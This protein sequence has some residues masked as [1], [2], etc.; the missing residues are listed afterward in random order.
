MLEAVGG[1]YKIVGGLGHTVQVGSLA[2]KL[3]TRWATVV[4]VELSA[5]PQVSL[6]SRDAG[7]VHIV[8]AGGVWID[9]QDAATKEDVARSAYF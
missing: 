6:P 8:D 5:V 4:E 3:T 7:E 2:K 1:E 9:G